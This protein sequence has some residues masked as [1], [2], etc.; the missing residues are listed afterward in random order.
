M[1]YIL[2]PGEEMT[3]DRK[4]TM[5]MTAEEKEDAEA[6]A[7]LHGFKTISA[8]IRALFKYAKAHPDM[9]LPS[10][11]KLLEQLET[12]LKKSTSQVTNTFE[13]LEIMLLQQEKSQKLLEWIT[14]KLGITDKEKREL[15]KKDMSGVA[16]F[17]D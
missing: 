4:F 10:G 8:L 7:E 9:F 1:F 5:L 12:S 3:S 16:I 11:V 2:F 6:L 13:K 17:E 15:L 14:Q